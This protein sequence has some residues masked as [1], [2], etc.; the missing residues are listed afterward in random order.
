MGASSTSL[1]LWKI[2]SVAWMWRGLPRIQ[3]GHLVKAACKGYPMPVQSVMMHPLRPAVLLKWPMWGSRT[4]K[5]TFWP[6]VDSIHASLFI[7]IDPCCVAPEQRQYAR[8]Y[9]T[10]R[11]SSGTYCHIRV[12]KHVKTATAQRESKSDTARGST[13][14]L[15]CFECQNT[16]QTMLGKVV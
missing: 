6:A 5:P 1:S 14:M 13:V 3:P 7:A 2:P 8:R 16:P 4:W 9:T 11:H 12:S 10:R 15:L